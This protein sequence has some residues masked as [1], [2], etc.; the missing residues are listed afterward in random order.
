MQPEI[1]AHSKYGKHRN[2]QVIM[3]WFLFVF[4]FYHRHVNEELKDSTSSEDDDFDDEK[5]DIKDEDFEFKDGEFY[6]FIVSMV[7]FIYLLY[8]WRVLLSPRQ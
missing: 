6:L 1:Y 3:K 7:S 8:P 2:S 4:S 5:I